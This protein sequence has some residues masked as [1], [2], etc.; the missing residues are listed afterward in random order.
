MSLDMY[1]KKPS[2]MVH[3]LQYYG[4]PFNKKM[5]EWAISRMKHYRKSTLTKDKVDALLHQ[6]GVVIEKNE[7]YDYVYGQDMAFHD[8]YNSSIINEEYLA[9]FIKDYIDDED[10]YPEVAFSRFYIDTVKKGIP[11]D[12]EGML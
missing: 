5:C 4:W 12:W 2:D 1:D 10:G 3:Y 7:L 8:F 11:I 9:K 6:Y